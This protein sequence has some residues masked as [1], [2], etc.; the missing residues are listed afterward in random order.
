MELR[1]RKRISNLQRFN[2]GNDDNSVDMNSV[3]QTMP[4][5]QSYSGDI[6]AKVNYGFGSKADYINSIRSDMSQFDSNIQQSPS[7]QYGQRAQKSEF[8]STKNNQLSDKM[9]SIA[10]M[11]AQDL[12]YTF[13]TLNNPVK[14]QDIMAGAGTSTGTINGINFQQQNNVDSGQLLKENSAEGVS[15]TLNMTAHGVAAGASIG[16]P[17]GGAIGGVLGLGL[18]LFNA[19]RRRKALKRAIWNANQ[20]TQKKNIFNR[21]GAYSESLQNQY[22]QDYGDTRNQLLNANRGKN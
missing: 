6:N 21:S 3:R 15:S 14:A 9:G 10:S 17:I 4:S 11:G 5:W 2:T 1:Q 19:G 18:G 8:Q 16:G 12:T 13:N 22:Y 20:L 7:F